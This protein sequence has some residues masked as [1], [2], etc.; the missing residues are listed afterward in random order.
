MDRIE[1]EIDE[2]L[3]RKRMIILLLHGKIRDG[4]DIKDM[5]VREQ[6]WS[7]E[8]KK[9]REARRKKEK[10]ERERLVKIV[11]PRSML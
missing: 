7:E 4:K 9:A 6:K 11:N 10:V 5:L 8:K 2:M 3:V 1:K